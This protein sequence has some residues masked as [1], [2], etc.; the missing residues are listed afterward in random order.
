MKFLQSS[1]SIIQYIQCLIANRLF[2]S[3]LF[4]SRIIHCF[5]FQDTLMH[6]L[7]YLAQD[8]PGSFLDLFVIN[9]KTLIC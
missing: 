7:A 1:F 3:Y 4:T 8:T 6:S 2:L 9:I 5:S